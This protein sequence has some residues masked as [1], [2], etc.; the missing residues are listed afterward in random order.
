VVATRP[1]QV[2]RATRGAHNNETQCSNLIIR[3]FENTSRT[4]LPKRFQLTL[5]GARCQGVS[6]TDWTPVDQDHDANSERPETDI[7]RWIRLRRT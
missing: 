2:R 4:E 3:S 7:E 5:L 1:L 6:A